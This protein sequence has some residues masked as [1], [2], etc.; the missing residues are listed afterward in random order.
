MTDEGN[1]YDNRAQAWRDIVMERYAKVA[2][3]L[4]SLST[5]GI[6]LLF[7]TLEFSHSAGGGLVQWALAAF[8]LTILLALFYL[9]WSGKQLLVFFVLRPS[10]FQELLTGE[11]S[12][13]AASRLGPWYRGL[14]RTNLKF[15]AIFSSGSFGLMVLSFLAGI[16]L[17]AIS[18]WSSSTGSVQ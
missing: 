11:R 13:A 5:W 14:A 17:L 15:W 7:G 6:L 2:G 10:A 1:S 8:L 3:Q 4:I 9:Y 16:S 12:T 18:V